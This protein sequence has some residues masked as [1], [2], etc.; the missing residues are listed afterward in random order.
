M[1]K[2]F[3][4]FLFIL[5]ILNVWSQEEI[6]AYYSRE[7]RLKFIDDEI[8]TLNERLNKLNAI[9]ERILSE[10]SLNLA[11][12][13]GRRPKIGLALSGGGAK[14]AAHVGVL[15]VLEEH[16]IPID[17]ITGT[18]I[19]SII[20]ALY[21]VGYT[22]QEIEDTM[23]SLHWEEL[24]NDTPDRHFT[25]IR[26]KIQTDKYFLNIEIDD[27]FNLK[28]PKGALRGEN[29]Y[30]TLKSLLWRAEGINNFDELPIPYRAVATDV[31][32]GE[33]VVISSGDL[34]R[35]A[36]KSMAIP[37]ALDPIEDKGKYF[38]DG[39]LS[40]N[41]PVKEL[42]DMGADIIIAIDISADA[43]IIDEGS[44]FIEILNIM[45]S[46]KGIEDTKFQKKIADVLIV[47]DVKKHSPVDFS[48][49]EEL[50]IRGEDEA[51][52]FSYVLSKLSYPDEFNKKKETLKE[53][54]ISVSSLK[55][56]GN[57]KLKNKNVT[58]LMEKNLPDTFS[59][60]E[61]MILMK[62]IY[63]LNYISR[64][65]YSVEDDVLEITVKENTGNYVRGGFHYDRDYGFSM[66][67]LLDSYEFGQLTNNMATELEISRYPKLDFKYFSSYNLKNLKFTGVFNIGLD[68]DPL[69]IYDKSDQVSE[70]NNLSS[71]I[72]FTGGTIIL[73]SYVIAAQVGYIR[74]DSSYEEGAKDFEEF[75]FQD[76]Y[77]KGK[78]FMASDRRNSL[79]YT[80]KGY[81]V[82]VDY[83]SGKSSDRN[84]VNFYGPSYDLKDY[85]QVSEKLSLNIFSSGGKISGD[86]IPVNEHFKIGG[87]RDNYLKYEYKFFGMNS[88]RKYAQEFLIAGAEFQYQL[89]KNLYLIGRYNALTYSTE[90]LEE[91]KDF[92]DDFF[93][94]YG[95]GVGWDT[96]IGPVDIIISNDVDN[97]GIL[98]NA[99]L[100]YTF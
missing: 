67:L 53:G 73:D 41:M 14:G 100:G 29:M 36:F 40:R 76:G 46:Y 83:F 97:D 54:E 99:S 71:Y 92:G 56:T 33:A 91:E 16:Q 35:A 3:M 52:K 26:D 78:F 94:G 58:D 48:N 11:R 32:T 82:L 50:I 4:L 79:F 80:T 44:G 51:R 98:F 93:Y 25:P 5:C 6:D 23:L 61:I 63:A 88:M 27:N 55:L 31:Q 87:I 60:D 2:I 43:T 65:F 70:Y 7:T 9:R 96:I 30:L 39:G 18:S 95:L 75:E 81:Y 62:K 20:G 86:A 85:Y 72:N 13:E 77:F 42:I 21:T 84:D 8:G 19:G 28:F 49:L 10:D 69:F 22:P 89:L 90:I 45:S 74:T 68:L 17:Y 38:V 15:K 12:F 47:P 37:T 24:F 66:N 1:K 34:A 59:K 57:E 64:V